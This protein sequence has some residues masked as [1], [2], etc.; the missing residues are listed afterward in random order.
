MTDRNEPG[1]QP[2]HGCATNASRQ[3]RHQISRTFPACEDDNLVSRDSFLHQCLQAFRQG[4]TSRLCILREN[5]DRR[6]AIAGGWHPDV[7]ARQQPRVL[8]DRSCVPAVA[9]EGAVHGIQGL[10][11]RKRLGLEYLSYI[12]LVVGVEED[13]PAPRLEPALHRAVKGVK[14]RRREEVLPLVDNDRVHRFDQVQI[15]GGHYGNLLHAGLRRDEASEGSAVADDSNGTACGLLAP[16]G[17]GSEERLSRPG[18]TRA[19]DP[20]CLLD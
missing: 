2:V 10:E 13:P 12:R 3:A 18:T 20:V 6:G 17:L 9:A 14:P 16:R 1:P 7:G 11:K 19:E 5:G 8:N 4:D 15:S